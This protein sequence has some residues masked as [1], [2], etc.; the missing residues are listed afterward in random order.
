MCATPLPEL[1]LSCYRHQLHLRRCDVLRAAGAT[2][3]L[4][5]HMFT[6]GNYTARRAAWQLLPLSCRNRDQEYIDVLIL[7]LSS[8]TIISLNH[9]EGHR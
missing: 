1:P 9:P 7:L 8:I 6:Q 2:R 5:L 4:R 3:G